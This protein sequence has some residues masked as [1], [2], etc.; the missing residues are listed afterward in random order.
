MNM[1]C[2]FFD[3]RVSYELVFCLKN[4]CC[5]LWNNYC[6]LESIFCFG[7]IYS[8]LW[9]NIA[10]YG[11]VVNSIHTSKY[12]FVRAT[13]AVAKRCS[14]KKV[15]LEISQNSQENTCVRDS[16][17]IKSLAQVFSFEFCGI[18]KSTFFY[19]IPPAAASGANLDS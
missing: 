8:V 19:R 5:G 18:S 14:V 12:G 9:N 2:I 7:K 11:L 1:C 16:F 10:A 17:L 6:V 4:S 13:E 3:K 15:F